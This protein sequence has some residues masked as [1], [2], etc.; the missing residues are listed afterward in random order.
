MSNPNKEKDESAGAGGGGR[1]LVCGLLH[2]RIAQV[3]TIT[4]SGKVKFFFIF[5]IS[6]IWSERRKCDKDVFKLWERRAGRV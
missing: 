4:Q 1:I 3:A 6:H 5:A 2:L